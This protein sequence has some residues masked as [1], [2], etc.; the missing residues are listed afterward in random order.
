MTTQQARIAIREAA[1][2][3]SLATKGYGVVPLIN[4]KEMEQLHRLFHAHVNE[5]AIGIKFD[6]LTEPT[7][8]VRRALH[9]GIMR[10][11]GHRIAQLMDNYRVV[12]CMYYVK[13]SDSD[14]ELGLHLDPSMTI[15]P[16]EHLGIWVPL[17]D[18]DGQGGEFCILP[19]SRHFTHPYHA[20]SIPSPYGQVGEFA[21]G[22]MDDLSVKAGHAVVFHNNMLHYSRPNVSGR[23][24]LALVIKMIAADAPL[25]TAFGSQKGD[26][27]D[28]ELIQ[29]PDDYYLT[30]AFVKAGRPEGDVLKGV[31][32]KHKVLSEADFTLLTGR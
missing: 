8:A 28:I 12:I 21:K 18:A 25:V 19:G 13:K 1:L 17:I 10:I 29:V 11:C 6:S 9:D 15:E 2:G 27:S 30:D 16:Y 14:T 32:V 24:R 3:H 23:T 20:L 22:H 5:E 31:E 7:V 4:G 26:T